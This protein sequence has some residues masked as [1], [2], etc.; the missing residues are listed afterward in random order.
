MKR[1]LF[2]IICGACVLLTLVIILLVLLLSAT[3]V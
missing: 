1:A 3:G 2:A